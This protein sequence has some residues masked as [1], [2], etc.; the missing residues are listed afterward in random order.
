MELVNWMELC[1][2]ASIPFHAIPCLSDGNA[3]Q[4]PF[5][6]LNGIFQN[7]SKSTNSIPILWYWCWN[8]NWMASTLYI[9]PCS[10]TALRRV[11]GR[12]WMLWWREH[13]CMPR[14]G[15]TKREFSDTNF[16]I[17]NSCQHFDWMLRSSSGRT[18]SRAVELHQLT[19]WLTGDVISN[20]WCLELPLF[21]TLILTG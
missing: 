12:G 1:C 14:Y 4:F 8:T 17:R 7:H 19:C 3:N 20:N 5:T 11:T 10:I 13:C 9:F 2:K 15:Q 18:P 21:A 6:S 16:E